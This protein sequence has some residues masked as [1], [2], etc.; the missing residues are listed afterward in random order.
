M[1]NGQI[2]ISNNRATNFLFVDFTVHVYETHARVGLECSD[3][4]EC[5]QWRTQLKQLYAAV[6]QGNKKYTAGSTDMAY[7]MM[8]LNANMEKYVYFFLLIYSIY[9]KM[10]FIYK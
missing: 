8:T 10:S 1:F 3:I 6:L 5:N 2:L 4:H 9:N 7:L